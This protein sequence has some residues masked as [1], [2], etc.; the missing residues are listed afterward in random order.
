M[1][2]DPQLDPG[3]AADEGDMFSCAPL[4]VTVDPRLVNAQD[5]TVRADFGQIYIEWNPAAPPD[6][7]QELV[8]LTALD[9]AMESGRRVGVRPGFID[10]M[11]P[12]QWNFGTPLRLEVWSA[13]PPD[14]R[15][16]WDHEVDADL[17]LG[18]G[19]LWI[20]GPPAAKRTELVAADVPAGDYRVRISGC[21]FTER[22]QAGADGD[23]SYRLR[24]W[25]RGESSPPVLRKRWP[26]W[27][28]DQA[29]GEEVWQR[30]DYDA[31]RRSMRSQPGHRIS[32]APE[33]PQADPPP[34]H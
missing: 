4:E 31:I 8:T 21:G 33:Q 25:P 28:P 19:G 12:G 14:D 30:P 22:G 1:V 20:G 32:V 29:A 7:P 24:L 23:D 15:D 3:T 10:V 13:E 6:D 18:P 34:D 17:D 26:G 2:A 9:D 16:G 27:E 5:L 11:T